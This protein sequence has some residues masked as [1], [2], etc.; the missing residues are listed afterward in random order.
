M[1]NKEI[2]SLALMFSLIGFGTACQKSTEKTKTSAS[3]P[4]ANDRNE[5]SGLQ[6][7]PEALGKEWLADRAG[8]DTKYKGKTLSISGDVWTAME[9]GDQAFVTFMGVPFDT[10]TGGAKI[11][12][13]TRLSPDARLLIAA[14][15]ANDQMM[16]ETNQKDVKKPTPKATVK[17]VYA[18]SAPAERPDGFVELS[19]CELTPNR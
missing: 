6:I 15:Q 17:G 19:P 7:T 13:I 18:Q 8:T 16:R 4:N 14:I 1:K 2:C 5:D 10:K 9:I 11:T 12:C 3:Q